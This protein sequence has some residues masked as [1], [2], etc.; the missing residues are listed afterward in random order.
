MKH[1]ETVKWAWQSCKL[2]HNDS[3]WGVENSTFLCG[4][5]PVF[6]WRKMEKHCETNSNHIPLWW[7][8]KKSW[9]WMDSTA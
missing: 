9:R 1:D 7:Q 2:Q 3:S 4:E 8:V 6:V 5:L